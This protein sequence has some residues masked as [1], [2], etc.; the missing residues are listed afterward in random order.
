MQAQYQEASV[1][2]VARAREAM[3]A[4][5]EASRLKLLLDSGLRQ[6]DLF[7]KGQEKMLKEQVQR[8]QVEVKLLKEERKRT[9]DV[10]LR[11]RASLWES[12]LEKEKLMKEKKGWFKFDADSEMFRRKFSLGELRDFVKGM[13]ETQGFMDDDDE[14]EMEDDDD[15]EEEDDDEDD[16]DDESAKVS[17]VKQDL[18]VEGDADAEGD[19][20]FVEEDQQ[21]QPSPTIKSSLPPLDKDS[22]KLLDDPLVVAPTAAIPVPAV[23]PVSSLPLLSPSAPAELGPETQSSIDLDEVPLPSSSLDL[24][25]SASYPAAYNGLED[26]S[27]FGPLTQVRLIISP[28]PFHRRAELILFLSPAPL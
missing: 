14:D 18:G 12:Y 9:N 5:A 10:E 28:P 8:L 20:D 3:V 7:Q 1:A 15:D 23:E 4:E 16:E 26:M 6:R 24:S 13:E 25:S 22:P 27:Q 2:A 21:P 17:F 11:T 19:A